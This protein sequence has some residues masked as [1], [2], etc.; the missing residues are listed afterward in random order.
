MSDTTSPLMGRADVEAHIDE[1]EATNA[2]SRSIFI[3][4]GYWVTIAKEEGKWTITEEATFGA[5]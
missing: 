3:R 2:T 4:T 5:Q 1:M